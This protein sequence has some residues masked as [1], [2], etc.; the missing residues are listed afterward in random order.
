MGVGAGNKTPCP[1]VEAVFTGPLVPWL[2]KQ[3][4]PMSHNLDILTFHGGS[5]NKNILYNKHSTIHYYLLEINLTCRAVLLI[6]RINLVNS[7]FSEI[8]FVAIMF[9]AYYCHNKQFSFENLL[10]LVV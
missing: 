6:L 7:V 8:P 1:V 4:F 10:L 2:S 5:S 9:S 3:N